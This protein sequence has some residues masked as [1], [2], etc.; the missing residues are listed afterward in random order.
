LVDLRKEFVKYDE[1]N[2]P[3]N[4][5]RGILTDDGVHLNRTGNLFVAEKI[6]GVIRKGIK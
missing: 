5:E 1:E 3:D 6:W 2:N 4:K